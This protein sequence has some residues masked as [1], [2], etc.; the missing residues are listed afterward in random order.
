MPL[1]HISLRVA[2]LERSRAFYLAALQPWGYRVFQTFPGVVGLGAWVPDFWLADDGYDGKGGRAKDGGV[3][4]Q[5]ICFDAGSR[6]EV[7]R[8][9]D[10][11]MYAPVHSSCH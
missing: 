2:D 3:A 7:R 9:Y 5:H 1:N 8:F 6:A 11:A 10:A 4:P